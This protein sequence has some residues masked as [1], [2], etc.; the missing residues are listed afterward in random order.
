M[1]GVRFCFLPRFNLA[2]NAG[3]L[4]ITQCCTSAVL[5]IVMLASAVW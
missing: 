4:R 2:S 3:C 1:D 5:R